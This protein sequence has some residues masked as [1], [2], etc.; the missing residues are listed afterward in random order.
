MVLLTDGCKPVFQESDD[1]SGIQSLVEVDEILLQINSR[2]LLNEPDMMVANMGTGR[3]CHAALRVSS[4]AT[5]NTC[6]RTFYQLCV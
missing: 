6:Q 3:S 4:R 5:S 1:G 2:P